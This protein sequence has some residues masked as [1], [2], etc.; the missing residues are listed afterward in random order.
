MLFFGY[1]Y[2]GVICGCWAWSRFVMIRFCGVL[3]M[4]YY[5]STFGSPIAILEQLKTPQD[6]CG[7][8]DICKS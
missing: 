5:G 3:F 2:F 7:V 6:Y 4:F 1:E 8:F